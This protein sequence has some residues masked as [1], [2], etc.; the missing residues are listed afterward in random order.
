MCLGQPEGVWGRRGS[1]SVA[2]TEADDEGPQL[3][4]HRTGRDTDRHRQPP[5]HCT[6]ADRAAADR[7]VCLLGVCV[8]ACVRWRAQLS[9]TQ[10]RPRV[11]NSNRRQEVS[12]GRRTSAWSLAEQNGPPTGWEGAAVAAWL[13]A[14]SP[15]PQVCRVPRRQRPRLSASHWVGRS[16]P[17]HPA[18]QTAPPPGR[19][20]RSGASPQVS[21]HRRPRGPAG[22]TSRLP[23]SPTGCSASKGGAGLRGDFLSVA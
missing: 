8:H 1:T 6:G 4:A 16:T 10:R 21:E 15:G 7:S 22:A 12:I 17:P 14:G 2:G 13:P 19:A 23:S 5:T 3:H 20:T 18:R 11:T 9:S